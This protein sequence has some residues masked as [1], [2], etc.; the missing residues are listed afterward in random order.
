MRDHRHRYTKYW[1]PQ[2]NGER[3]YLRRCRES[4]CVAA[5]SFNLDYTDWDVAQLK[6][7][8]FKLVKVPGKAWSEI[9]LT[10]NYIQQALW[11]AGVE[12]A[13]Q[14]LGDFDDDMFYGEWSSALLEG[15]DSP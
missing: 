8:G 9:M 10:F 12:I 6:T 7:G 1:S 2:G 15:N 13:A 4:G 14:E 11:L 5:E 3:T